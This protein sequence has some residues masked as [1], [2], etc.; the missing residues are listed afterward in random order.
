VLEIFTR[1][2]GGDPIPVG[3]ELRSDTETKKRMAK[4]K[5]KK[6]KKTISCYDV[7]AE[8]PD[9]LLY[10]GIEFCPV[11]ELQNDMLMNSF[12]G[13]KADIACQHKLIDSADMSKC[14]KILDLA[15]QLAGK[16]KA[17]Y[18]YL[19]D[20]LAYPLQSGRK[21]GV[22]V[23]V[24][25]PHG[26][27][28]GNFFGRLMGQQIYGADARMKGSG[29]FVQL[30]GGKQLFK[31]FNS[32]STNKMFV[33]CDEVVKMTREQCDR[34]KSMITE[35]TRLMT[36][37]GKDT[38]EVQDFSNYVFTCNHLPDGLLEPGDR[39]YFVLNAS[40]DHAQ[41]ADYHSAVMQEIQGDGALHF[42]QFLISREISAFKFGEAPP[43][44]EMKEKLRAQ[45]IDPVWR[46]VRALIDDG[47]LPMRIPRSLF[48]EKVVSFCKREGYDPT[49][50]TS[51][52]LKKVCE[53]AFPDIRFDHPTMC[54]MEDGKAQTV[55]CIHFPEAQKM[56]ERLIA[57][58][59]W[60]REEELDDEVVVDMLQLERMVITPGNTP[61]FPM[62]R[63][64]QV[65]DIKPAVSKPPQPAPVQLPLPPTAMPQPPQPAPVQLPLPP[66]AM[67]QPPQPAP[68][69][70]PLPP[71]AMPQPPQ[72]APV[73]LPLPPTAMPQPPQPAH[74]SNSAVIT[75]THHEPWFHCDQCGINQFHPPR[76]M[77]ISTHNIDLCQGC[78]NKQGEVFQRLGPFIQISELKSQEECFQEAN[79]AHQEWRAKLA[80]A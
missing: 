16:D 61:P 73:Q 26:C 56:K 27:G 41:D 28:K 33:L 59:L 25:G 49:W 40:A 70:L 24:K 37:K 68:V 42:Y 11:L 34:L 19:L 29:L 69:Q 52:E 13:F 6:G 66:T 67:P 12:F 14:Q 7:W 43:Q 22:A 57:A 48:H 63:P 32:E 54:K 31:D 75:T 76:F 55:R 36:L 39:R 15:F 45:G 46:Y 4:C 78:V 35:N 72:P 64:K 80:H 2:N 10:H 60:I 18:E 53:E 38:E 44:T 21:T 50:K 3:Y 17:N 79:A 23:L 20:W 47:R 74:L 5:M 62:Q 8:H 51:T 58:K 30:D 1:D 65:A 9:Q 71:T 77:S